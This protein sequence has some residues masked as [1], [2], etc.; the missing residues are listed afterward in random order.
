MPRSRTVAQVGEFG[1]L[2]RLLPT[3]GGGR[4]VIVGAGDD[5]AVIA[6]RSSR[7]VVTV[8][9]LVEDVHFRP[10]WLRPAQIGRKA[11]LVNLSDVA[12]MGA[13]PRFVLVSVGVPPSYPARDLLA[14]HRGIR[15]A[16]SET[17]AAV[18][19]GNVSRAGK[20]FVSITLIGES[21]APSARRK[22]A[23]PGDAVCV[24][25]SLGDAALGVRQLLGNRNARSRAV[26]R[27]REPPNRLQAGSLL[28]GH[29]VV[30]AMIDVSDGLLQDLGHLCRS[31]GV[32]AHLELERVPCSASVRA[33]GPALVLGGG[34]DYELLFTVSRERLGRLQRVMPRLGCPVTRIGEIVPKSRGVR[35]FDAAGNVVPVR[36]AGHDH[37][38]GRG[39]P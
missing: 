23:R 14:L 10:H 18:V 39:R 21:S 7:L 20:L 26:A 25:G 35:V 22:G 38:A 24:T 32:G 16:A 28:V 34:E 36:H 31:S 15:E 6:P 5:C 11:Y 2:K 4:G 1:F 29:G 19:G 13:R 12:A 9:A 8:D 27:F 3:L 33:G 30:S 17:G 37:F